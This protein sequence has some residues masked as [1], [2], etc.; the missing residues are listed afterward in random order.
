VPKKTPFPTIV[1]SIPVAKSTTFSSS[2]T[3]NSF[4]PPSPS[5][6]ISSISSST[7]PPLP[8]IDT[9]STTHVPSTHPTL[10]PSDDE[11]QPSDDVSDTSSVGLSPSEE[12]DL[13]PLS[14]P[15]SLDQRLSKRR[16]KR[17]RQ[18]TV[19]LHAFTVEQASRT[20]LSF[21][22]NVA[23][24]PARILTDSGAE[25]NV[26]SSSFVKEH[27]LPRID[28]P[29]IPIIL[30]NGSSSISSHTSTFSITR[31]NYNDKLD[32]LIYPLNNY[33][34]ILGKPWLTDINP[35]INW[36]NNDLH[37]THNNKKVLWSC[38]GAEAKSITFRSKGRLLSHLHFH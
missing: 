12:V 22:G 28:G 10:V 5:L 31:D 29:P 21:I 7:P 1:A 38:R 6:F 19:R 34:L 15:A 35:D 18:K 14:S 13:D 23:G 2:F 4:F 25:G 37:F 16:A 20:L 11:L 3:S 33:H 27:S 30:P 32:A 8:S 17:L 26:I 36:R 24:H 9:N